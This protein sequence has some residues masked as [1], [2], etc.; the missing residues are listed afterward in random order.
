M[1]CQTF[2]YTLENEENLIQATC[3]CGWKGRVYDTN[4]D[5][6]AYSNADEE[7]CNHKRNE[8]YALYN[9][10]IKLLRRK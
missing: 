10:Y 9:K 6:F 7:A 4:S 3:S 5:D 8:Q 2:I 1:L